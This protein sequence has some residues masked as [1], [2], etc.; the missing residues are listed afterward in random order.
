MQDKLSIVE[1]EIRELIKEAEHE[2]QKGNEKYLGTT[3]DI[4]GAW[5]K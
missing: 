5:K 2:A 1:K 4:S 3:E